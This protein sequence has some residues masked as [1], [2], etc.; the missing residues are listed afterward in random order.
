MC[1]AQRCHSDLN[2]GRCYSMG[3]CIQHTAASVAV[4][5]AG[6]HLDLFHFVKLHCFL[7][8]FFKLYITSVLVLT[9]SGS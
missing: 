8:L 7:F 6:E 5:I 2:T 9:E 4:K 3:Q 1:P